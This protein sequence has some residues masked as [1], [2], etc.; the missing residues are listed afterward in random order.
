MPCLAFGVKRVLFLALLLL[1]PLV[2]AEDLTVATFNIRFA[3]TGDKGTRSW[4]A[5]KELVVETVRK[6]NPDVWGVQEAL[7]HQMEFLKKKLPEY[8]VFGVARNDGKTKGEYSAIF[9]RKKR[10]KRDEKQGGTFWLSDT[11]EKVGTTSWGN[12]VIR[13]C[14]WSRLVDQK[15]G[16]GVYVF[17]THWDHRSQPSREQS[18]RLLG[19]RI[20]AR[21]NKNEPVVLLGDFN[22]TETNPGVAYLIGKKVKLAGGTEP[23]QWKSSLRSAFLELHPKVED[24]NTFNSWKAYH[25]GPFMIDHVLVSKEWTVKKS[26]IEYH[27]KDEMVPSDHWPVA[28]VLSLDK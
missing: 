28:A 20:E 23:K 3:H 25:K 21:K 9:L 14:T 13:I 11:P 2:R 22:A 10:F 17:N 4:E 7:D 26:W 24:R 5:R 6:M 12:E 1:S 8:Q 16:K 19:K 18:A 15:S 27:K